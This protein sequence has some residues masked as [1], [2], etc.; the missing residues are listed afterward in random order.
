MAIYDD[1]QDTYTDFV[2]EK[3]VLGTLYYRLTLH[4]LA[5]YP[6]PVLAKLTE[7]RTVYQT[8]TGDRHLD[9]LKEHEKYG[10]WCRRIVP[11]N[12]HASGL[13]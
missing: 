8:T 10:T 9:L 6:G 11:P 5:K 2:R 13:R 4:P 12:L 7:W 1:F 3:F